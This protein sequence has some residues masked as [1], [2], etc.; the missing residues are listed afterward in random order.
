MLNL[1]QHSPRQIAS[2][3]NPEGGLKMKTN[4]QAEIKYHLAEIIIGWNELTESNRMAWV[5]EAE[6]AIAETGHFEVAAHKN[7]YGE[8]RYVEGGPR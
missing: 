5:I 1:P 4:K 6:E 7:V 8:L 2:A 3:T